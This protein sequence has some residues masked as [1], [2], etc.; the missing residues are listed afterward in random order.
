MIGLYP[1]HLFLRPLFHVLHGTKEPAK[2]EEIGTTETMEDYSKELE[3]SF[4]V[5]KEGDVLSGSVIDALQESHHAFVHGLADLD[6][7]DSLVIHIFLHL[8]PA[9]PG[10][11]VPSWIWERA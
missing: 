6:S 3:A 4:R 2:T 5:I 7:D 10:P 1:G 11:M 9:N 8:V